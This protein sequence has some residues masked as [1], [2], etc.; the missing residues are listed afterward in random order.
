MIGSWGLME[1]SMV[2]MKVHDHY[3]YQVF[4]YELVN[5]L[6]MPVSLL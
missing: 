1:V 4:I 5:C 3:N 2:R 6:K